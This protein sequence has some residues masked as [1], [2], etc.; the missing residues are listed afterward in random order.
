VK[1]QANETPIYCD[2]RSVVAAPL[3]LVGLACFASNI[4]ARATDPMLP[5]I[6]DAAGSTTWPRSQQP[7]L[8]VRQQPVA[9]AP[10]G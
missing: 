3:F 8:A 6:A 9:A 2:A 10:T 5:L 7:L 1:N 4:P